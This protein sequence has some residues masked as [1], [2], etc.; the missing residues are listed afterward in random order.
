MFEVECTIRWTS[1]LHHW[2]HDFRAFLQLPEWRVLRLRGTRRTTTSWRGSRYD[3]SLLV[4]PSRNPGADL[5]HRSI[6]S[7]GNDWLARGR[8]STA[9]R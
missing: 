8:R 4:D 2:F 1:T 3:G 5:P 6:S 9:A 7:N